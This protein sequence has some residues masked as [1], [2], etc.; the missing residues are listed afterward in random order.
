KVDQPT[1]KTTTLLDEKTGDMTELIEPSAKLSTTEKA[2]IEEWIK[3]ILSNPRIKGVAL[4][5]SFPPGLSP[6]TYH[7]I[8]SCL[9]P[10]NI[11]D[12]PV[13]FVDA[14]S[15][16]DCLK[17]GRI[18]ILKINAD[19]A[20]NL[21]GKGSFLS[22]SKFDLENLALEVSNSFRIPTVALTNG[23]KLAALTSTSGS[24]RISVLYTLPDLVE[25]LNQHPEFASINSKI[26]LNPIG[27]GDT[28]S[29]VFF[30][31]YL[32]TKNPEQSFKK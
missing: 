20:S 7:F 22:D 3:D 8:S 28:C 4:C 25:I 11:V 24:D 17:S 21:L 13:L 19:E 5:G 31:E 30:T 1:R 15:D 18:D 29:A 26:L 6:N 12:R 9:L 16:L 2:K 32:E 27:A 10:N 14:V 23:P